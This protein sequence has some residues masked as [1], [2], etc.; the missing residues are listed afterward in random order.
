[1]L[2]PAQI[3]TDTLKLVLATTVDGGASENT[4]NFAG[5]TKK[6]LKLIQF[7]VSNGDCN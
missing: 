4:S 7:P 6:L 2:S 1:M 3:S 5:S